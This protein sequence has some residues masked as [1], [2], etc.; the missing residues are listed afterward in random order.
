MYISTPNPFGLPFLHNHQSL[1]E[2]PKTRD[3]LELALVHS[4]VCGGVRAEATEDAALKVANVLATT[5][6]NMIH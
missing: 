5:C 1:S 3:T 2:L 4:A 6:A